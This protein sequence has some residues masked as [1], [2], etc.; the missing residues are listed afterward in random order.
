[1]VTMIRTSRDRTYMFTLAVDGVDLV[2]EDVVEALVSGE[3]EVYPAVVAG[4]ATLTYRLSADNSYD[5]VIDAVTHAHSL[6]P[7]VKVCRVEVD[8]VSISD[9]AGR[10]GRPRESVRA[11]VVGSRGPKDFP[12]PLTV[13]GD[14]VRVWDWPSVNQWLK[15]EGVAGHDEEHLLSREE[16]DELNVMLVRRFSGLHDSAFRPDR[17]VSRSATL[18]VSGAK[19]AAPSVT[20]TSSSSS[21]TKA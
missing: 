21:F 16:I 10:L 17:S 7:H 2:D 1:M 9:I 13:I 18:T 15:R 20:Y 14:G 19:V 5:A 12:T 4:K 3:I 11:W 6:L 8:L